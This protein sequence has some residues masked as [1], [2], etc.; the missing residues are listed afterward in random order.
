[1]IGEILSRDF[2]FARYLH[3]ENETDVKPTNATT[4]KKMMMTL[5]MAVAFLSGAKAMSYE[6]AR[7]QARF[8]TDKMAY[9]LNLNDAQY[10]DAYEINLDYLM[11]LRTADDVYGTMLTYRNAD[12]RCILYDWQYS[13]FVAADYFFHPVYWRAG[14]W[15]FPIYRHYHVGHFYYDHPHVFW[16]YRG[17]HGRVHHTHVSYYTHRRPAWDGGFRGSSRQA[18]TRPGAPHNNHRPAGQSTGRRPSSNGHEHATTPGQTRPGAGPHQGGNA[19]RTTGRTGQSTSTR[20]G[21]TTSAPSAGMQTQPSRSGNTRSTRPSA[22]P[23]GTRSTRS[24]STPS[25]ARNSATTRSTGSSYQRQSSTR[26]T[27]SRNNNGGSRSSGARPTGNS[28]RSRSTR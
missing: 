21:A 9:E 1:M 13:L 4:M 26:T 2:L 28:T 15:V 10:N 20:R 5:I 3:R 14:A 11:G 6:E 22:G 24:V 23:T 25:G 8:L 7:E 17:T 12:L 27:V 16:S 19:G 18:V